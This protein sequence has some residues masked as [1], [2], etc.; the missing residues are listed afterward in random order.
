[1]FSYI[2]PICRNPIKSPPVDHITLKSLIKTI[3]AALEGQPDL[4]KDEM[5]WVDES[6]V[7]GAGYFTGLFLKNLSK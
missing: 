6:A 7:T 3:R 1:M 4:L 2:C 5:G